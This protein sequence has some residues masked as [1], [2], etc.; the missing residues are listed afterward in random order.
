[1]AEVKKAFLG[2][3]QWEVIGEVKTDLRI[4]LTEPGNNREGSRG[5]LR[6]A[7]LVTEC[8]S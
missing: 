3:K 6:E 1:M 8:K 5:V 2:I 7:C 4:Q